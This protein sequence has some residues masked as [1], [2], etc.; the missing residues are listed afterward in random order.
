[1]A[2]NA[3][4]VPPFNKKHCNCRAIAD[5]VIARH[6]PLRMAFSALA[7]ALLLAGADVAHAEQIGGGIDLFELHPG[8]GNTHLVLESTWEL[9]QAALKLDG[10]SDTR[11]TFEDVE[12]QALWMPEV[13][14]GVKVGLG[15]RQDLRPGSNLTHGV[16]GVEAELLPWLAAEHYFFLS[17]HGDLTGSA[18]IVGRFAISPRLTLEPRAQLD[19]AGR[20]IPHEGLAAGATGLELSARLRRSLGPH[21]DVYAGVIH[22][23]TLGRS[24]AIANA[25]G[26]PVRITRGVVGAGFSL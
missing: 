14:H 17:E 4:C 13:A 18:K 6:T 15:A 10:G 9:G 26:S 1:M 25:S 22:E 8:R 7:A 16:A 2:G 24:A 23:R 12:I 11:P 5:Q 3:C 21:F 20:D 19:W